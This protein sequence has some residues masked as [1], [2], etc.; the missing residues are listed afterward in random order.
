MCIML[1][2]LSPFWKQTWMASTVLFLNVGQGLVLGYMSILTAALSAPDSSIKTDLASISWLAAPFAPAAI[3]GGLSSCFFMGWQG[4]RKAY[5]LFNIPGIIGLLLTYFAQN[6]LTLLIARI[7]LGITG[8]GLHSVSIVAIAEYVHPKYRCMFLNCKTVFF[9]SGIT[10]V[11]ALGHYIHWRRAAVM[12][13]IPHIL[14]FIMAFMWTESPAWFASKKRFEECKDAFFW[15]RGR[16]NSSK[17]EV[18]EMI[19]AQ[20]ER[21][22]NNKKLTNRIYFLELLKKITRSDFLKPFLI[23]VCAVIVMEMSGRHTYPAYALQFMADI[24]GSQTQYY[25]YYTISLDLII[26]VSAICSSILVRIINIRPLL[27]CTGFSALV[28]L[29]LGCIYLFLVSLD[30]ISNDR[31]WIVILL[32]IVYFF[33]SNLGCTPIP[34]TLAAEIFPLE[35]RV[36]ATSLLS[37]FAC[38]ILMVNLK[39]VPYLLVQIKA[40]GTFAIFGTSTTIGLVA[41]YFI[42][43]ETKNKTLQEIE[44]YFYNRNLKNKNDNDLNDDYDLKIVNDEE[45]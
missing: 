6:Y 38:V 5:I 22:S 23:G 44:D 21:L 29:F 13:L 3:I 18:K 12:I 26:I 10:I 20:R 28:A 34:I 30:V 41:L 11:H 33:L 42:L 24:V 7:L 8:G 14:S 4:R 31:P 25:Y 1:N 45:I 17:W 15:I 40:Y 9:S 27:F 16:S 2:C 19:K 39:I 32:F 36:L 35:H 43:P 37:T